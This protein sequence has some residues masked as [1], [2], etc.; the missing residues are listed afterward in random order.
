MVPD[1]VTLNDLEGAVAVILVALA[2]N[3]IKMVEVR[4][5]VSV[6]KM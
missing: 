1:L 6:I 5:L 3:C 2:A 4:F